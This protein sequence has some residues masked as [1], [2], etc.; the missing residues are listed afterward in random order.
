MGLNYEDLDDVTRAHMLAEF[1]H[2][3]SEGTLYFSK[4]FST[5]GA[6]RYPE[7]L[8]DAILGGDD[9]TLARALAEPGIFNETHPRTTADGRVTYPRVPV[10]APATLAEGEFNRFYL[11]GISART[12]EDGGVEI[13]IYRA[14]ESVHPREESKALVGRRLDATRLLADLRTGDVDTALHLPP[15]PN[16]GLSGRVVQQATD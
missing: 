15:G 13:E 2:D 1:E 7:L 3:L 4:Y 10:T 12:I 9:D 6:E 11:R 14:R 8:R 5:H 16:S